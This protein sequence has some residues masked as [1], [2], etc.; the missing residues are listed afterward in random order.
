ML[1]RTMNF[2]TACVLAGV[3]GMQQYRQRHGQAQLQCAMSLKIALTSAVY[4]LR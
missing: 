3:Q 1:C 2:Y 4:A